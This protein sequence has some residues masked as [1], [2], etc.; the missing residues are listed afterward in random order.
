MNYLGYEIDEKLLAFSNTAEQELKDIFK[1]HEDVAMLWSARVLSAFQHS[2][3]AVTDFSEV[4]GYGYTDDGREK[5]EKIYAEIFGA[6]D[7]LVRPQ[8]MSGTHAINLCFTGLLKHGDTFISISGEPYDSLRTIIGLTGDSRNSL[9]KNGIKYEQIDL[10]DNDFDYEKI[11]YRIKLGGVKLVE[12]QRSR[13]YSQRDSISIAKIEKVCK[14]IKDINSDVI[15]MVDNCYGDM[16]EDREPTHIGADIIVGSLMKNLGGGEAKTGG[17]IVGK[18]ILIEDIAER[19]SAPGLGKDIGANMNQLLSFY[20]GIYN[21]PSVVCNA[22]KTMVYASYMLEKLGYTVDPKYNAKRTDIIQTITLKSEKNLV[23]FCKGI[24][25]GSPVESYLT[26]V[27]APMPGYP[28][29]EV[30]AGGSFIS[31]STIELSADGPV[32]PPYTAYMQGG[33]T[34][35][36]GK[37]GI[38]IGINEILK[39]KK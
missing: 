31:G 10:V 12:I 32:V 20:K 38:L 11:A 5:L 19:F 6:E 36:Y 4:T 30:M 34:Y 25:F 23:A 14:L 9:I 27:P 1:H 37:L 3:V 16:V 17:Y 26:P 24:Q 8:I 7:A 39:S 29:D 18:K 21:A 35:E 28:D 15:I 33:L 2:R 13:G 22:M